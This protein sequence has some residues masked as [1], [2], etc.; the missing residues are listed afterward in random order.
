MQRQ[1]NATQLVKRN[2][3][4]KNQGKNV[5]NRTLV[6]VFGR[7]LPG[8]YASG[9]QWVKLGMKYSDTFDTTLTTGAIL[10]QVFRANSL[11]D[12][13][14]TNAGHQPLT[15]D[16]YALLYNRYHVY[17][18]S[19]SITFAA[20]ADAYHIAC[21]VVNGTETFTSATDFRTFREGPMVRDYTAT[22]GGPAIRAQGRQDLWKFNGEGL[23][24]YMTDDRFGSTVVLN[25]VEI[26]DFHVMLYN[27]T[28]NS[29]LIHWVVDLKFH[30]I[31]H[32][33]ILNDPSSLRKRL[34]EQEE[35][36]EQQQQVR[37]QPVQKTL[38]TPGARRGNSPHC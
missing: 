34:Q 21:G 3:K 4:R 28:A 30:C 12:P 14:R 26:L 8:S 16:A 10:D 22:F 1:R 23:R 19:W 9:A 20:A 6:Q 7:Q 29:V 13:D 32:D 33:P 17:A 24:A 31:M 35:F 15:F 37:R 11:F 27:P 2:P 25:P 18:M 38:I 5:I 36:R